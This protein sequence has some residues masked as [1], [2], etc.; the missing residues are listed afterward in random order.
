M[1]PGDF[2]Y[3]LIPPDK[4]SSENT[5]S[6][7][8]DHTT[9]SHSECNTGNSECNTDNSECNT[10]NS[11]S[12]TTCKDA[13]VAMG[14]RRVVRDVKVYRHLDELMQ[15]SDST[16]SSLPQSLV[17]SYGDIRAQGSFRALAVLLTVLMNEV[18]F[19]EQDKASRPTSETSFSM[20]MRSAA[21][22]L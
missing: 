9:R 12:L 7:N 3:V 6:A 15:V 13:D 8:A 11:E 21:A 22:S 17:K 16:N 20:E 14:I 5:H 2:I 1:V 18:G 19:L 4:V 10:G